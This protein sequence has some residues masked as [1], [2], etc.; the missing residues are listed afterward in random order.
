MDETTRL[1]KMLCEL[2]F[3]S[4]R[5]TR[6]FQLPEAKRAHWDRK[7]VEML[8]RYDIHPKEASS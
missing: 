8:R 6:Y 4:D 5:D 1:A 2:D 3:D 7:A